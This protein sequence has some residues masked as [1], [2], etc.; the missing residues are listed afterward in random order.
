MPEVPPAIG[1]Q[2]RD[3]YADAGLTQK[4]FAA[5]VGIPP[6]TLTNITAGSSC[7]RRNAAK[8]A[9]GLNA[10]LAER[11]FRADWTPE[12]VLGKRPETSRP[13]DNRP[14][15]DAPQPPPDAPKRSKPTPKKQVAA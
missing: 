9:H 7:S 15:K 5:M 3:A 6:K 11:D 4:E 14:G 10:V 1:A 13:A 8:I 2:I 12:R